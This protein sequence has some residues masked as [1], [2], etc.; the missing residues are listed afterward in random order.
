MKRILAGQDERV[1]EWMRARLPFEQSEIPY[2]AIGLL[3]EVGTLCAGVMYEYFTRV[4]V[5]AHIVAERLT[6]HFIGEAFRYPFLQ[7]GVRRITVPVVATNARAIGFVEGLGFVHEGTMRKRWRDGS[8]L[9]IY[10][11]LRAECRWLEVGPKR[12]YQAATPFDGQE[13][14]RCRV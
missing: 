3:T 2:T 13:H 11:M 8:D 7:L 12:S 5:H 6:R 1:M 4:D 10:G 9:L 14:I